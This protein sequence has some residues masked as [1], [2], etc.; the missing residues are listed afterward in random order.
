MHPSRTTVSPGPVVS[1]RSGPLPPPPAP[2][3][4][5]SSTP[6]LR[7]PPSYPTTLTYNTTSRVE[8]PRPTR[9]HPPPHHLYQN[10]IPEIPPY[11]NGISPALRP[12]RVSYGPLRHANNSSAARASH[13]AVWSQPSIVHS[14]SSL[15][16]YPNS[17]HPPTTEYAHAGVCY[18]PSQYQQV[19][20]LPHKSP[21]ELWKSSPYRHRGHSIGLPGRTTILKPTEGPQKP[22]V[23][24]HQS[25]PVHVSKRNPPPPP[26]PRSGSWLASNAFASDGTTREPVV[27]SATPFEMSYSHGTPATNTMFGHQSS[28]FFKHQ[29]QQSQLP[30]TPASIV[31][32]SRVTTDSQFNSAVYPI[33]ANGHRTA[34]RSENVQLSHVQKCQPGE[35]N[36]SVWSLDGE[37]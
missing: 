21:I 34:P 27:R 13:P 10:F 36:R 6:G 3:N 15:L 2:Y 29:P 35:Q 23:I 32:G 14:A 12:D 33:Y 4:S 26:P 1:G 25:G 37:S 19:S 28:Q 7:R 30:L 11:A 5:S 31:H 9:V 8:Q 16:P 22:Q 20:F 18:A 17:N 24:A